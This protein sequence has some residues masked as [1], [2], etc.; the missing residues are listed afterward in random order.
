MAENETIESLTQ[1]FMDRL[2]KLSEKNGLT[3]EEAKDLAGM[4]PITV[5]PFVIYRSMLA[6]IDA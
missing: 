1:E 2:S 6:N 5:L 4:L 3:M